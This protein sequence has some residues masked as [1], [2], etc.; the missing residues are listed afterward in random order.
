MVSHHGDMTTSDTGTAPPLTDPRSILDRA[1]AMG[2]S[3]VADVGPHQLHQPTPC[4]EMDVRQ[5][6]GHLIGVLD[7]IAA[8]GN[9]DDPFGVI[10]THAPD[11]GWSNTWAIAGGRATNAWR[12]DAV[13]ERP[14]ALPWIQGSGADVLTSYFSELTVHLWDLA[15]ATGQQPV[16]DDAVVTAALEARPILP[17]EN[18]RALFEE[19]SATMGVSEV[20]TPFAEAVPVGADTPAIERLVA[21]NGRDPRR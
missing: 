5:M 6:L 3:V 1:L 11:D 12:D 10:E 17:A 16:W 20:A 8:L 13:L 18:R 9:G 4:S 19:I 7:R 15:V 2:A 21:W 14:M